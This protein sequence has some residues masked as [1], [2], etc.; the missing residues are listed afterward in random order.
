MRVLLGICVLACAVSVHGLA[1]SAVAEPTAFRVVD[2][3]LRCTVAPH[4]GVRRVEVS[5]RTGTRL[6][7][8]ATKWKLLA[9]AGVGDPAGGIAGVSAGNPLAP[10]EPGFPAPP[11]RLSFVAGAKCRTVEQRIPLSRRGLDGFAASPL[12]DKYDCA[13]GRRVLV[14]IRATFT[15]PTTLTLKRYRDGSTWWVA[16][17]T[18]AKGELAVR[19]DEGRTL[20]YAEVLASGSARLFLAD[21][22][23]PHTT[24]GIGP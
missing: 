4:A 19:T 6:F 13:S 7:G 8:D 23:K 1:D 3:T 24:Y 18:V 21:R 22:C 12:E 9:N 5:A 11:E 15:A 17:G 10:L 2:R 14:R 20:A 16:R